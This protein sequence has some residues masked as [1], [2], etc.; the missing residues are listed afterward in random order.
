MYSGGACGARQAACAGKS[1]A[2]M[3]SATRQCCTGWSWEELVHGFRQAKAGSWTH[4]LPLCAGHVTAGGSVCI[5]A[6]TQSGGPG[7]WRPD[8]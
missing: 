5:E 6:L 1:A 7:A 4:A 8:L 2:L 3:A